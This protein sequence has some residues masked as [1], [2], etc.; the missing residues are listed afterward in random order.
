MNVGYQN[1]VLLG[2][3]W[4][5]LLLGFLIRSNSIPFVVTI[6]ITF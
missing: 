2:F 3:S 5:F 6:I 4:F 1:F